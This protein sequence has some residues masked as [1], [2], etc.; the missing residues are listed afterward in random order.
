M[1]RGLVP[2]EASFGSMKA[3]STGEPE[4]SGGVAESPGLSEKFLPS[5]RADDA[6]DEKVGGRL[7]VFDCPVGL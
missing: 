7:E 4:H 1:C 5:D 6:V 2:A 3:N